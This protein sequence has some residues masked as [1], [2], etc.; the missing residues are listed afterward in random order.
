[1]TIS[2]QDQNEADAQ[3][4]DG[5]ADAAEACRAVGDEILDEW[6]AVDVDWENHC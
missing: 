2:D 1:M 4:R 3:V 6:L 5:W